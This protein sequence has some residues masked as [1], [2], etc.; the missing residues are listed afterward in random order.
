MRTESPA[1]LR[2]LDAAQRLFYADGIAATGVDRI[3]AEAGV[4]KPTLY[5]HFGTKDALVDAV[6][7]R[8]HERRG[9][10]LR[11][12][13]D[14]HAHSPRERLLAVF[15]W[16]AEWQA[17]EGRRGCAFLNA[18]AEVRDGTALETIRAHKSW[19][20]GELSALAEAAGVPDPEQFGGDLL[21]LLDGANGRQLVHGEHTAAAAR[22]RRIAATLLDATLLDAALDGPR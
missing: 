3:V 14:E 10:E 5:T 9:A 17:D 18:A 16:L 2:L 20:L 1:R 6:L 21:L 13:L 15:D 8:R 11:E 4:A 7:R 22:A 19:W 12:Y